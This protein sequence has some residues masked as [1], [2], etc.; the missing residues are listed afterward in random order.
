MRAGRRSGQQRKWHRVTGACDDRWQASLFN[1]NLLDLILF[2][3][4]TRNFVKRRIV[5]RFTAAF[6]HVLRANPAN[7]T[8]EVCLRIEHRSRYMRTQ[9]FGSDF[10]YFAPEAVTNRP[11]RDSEQLSNFLPLVFGGSKCQNGGISLAELSN[12]AFEVETGVYLADPS[13]VCRVVCEVTGSSGQ[14]ETTQ[15]GRVAAESPTEGYQEKSVL[16]GGQRCADPIQVT[17]DLRNRILHQFGRGPVIRNEKMCPLT[18]LFPNLMAGQSH[19]GPNRPSCA[20]HVPV[21]PGKS[22]PYARHHCT[23]D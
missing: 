14:F 16:P 4:Q 8:I 15:L 2:S 13:I 22:S 18:G 17:G 11:G 6:L 1:F 5:L 19:V 3:R 7:H 9:A 21:P 23:I 12:D 20:I 10:L